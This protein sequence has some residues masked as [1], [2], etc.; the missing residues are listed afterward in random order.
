[1]LLLFSVLCSLATCVAPQAYA[2]FDDLGSSARPMGMGNAY[3]AIA[4]DVNAL[5]YN[6]AGLARLYA[7]E[8]TSSYTRYLIGL[9]DE[10]NLGGGY[11]A[12]ALPLGEMGGLGIGYTNFQLAGYY[13]EHVLTVGYGYQVMRELSVGLN[14]K[15][16]MS[17]IGQDAYTALD[18]LFAGGYSTTNF[19]VDLGAIYQIAP[20][21]RVALTIMNLNQP[22]MALAGEDRVPTIVKAGFA[23]RSYGLDVVSDVAYQTNTRDLDFYF[24]AEKWFAD[25]S[26]AMRAGL[27]FGSREDRDASVGASYRTDN[28]QMDY[29][30][31]YPL[32]GLTKTYGTHRMALS[33]RFGDVPKESE[34]DWGIVPMIPRAMYDEELEKVRAAAKATQVQVEALQEQLKK[35]ETEVRS[36]KSEVN[37]ANVEKLRTELNENSEKLASFMKM[38][39]DQQAK[40]NALEEAKKAKAAREAQAREEA[41]IVKEEVRSQKSEVSSQPTAYSPQPSVAGIPNT[42][43]AAE[44][45]T[46]RSVAKRFYGSE[47]KWVDIYRMNEDRIKQGIITPGQILIM[48]KGK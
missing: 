9:G 14:V 32:A 8:V 20:S 43:T 24:G 41:K 2:N 16:L 47:D 37:D 11:L 22:N 7:P 26:F 33:V 30:F 27:G 40:L 17:S 46:L 13:Q 25:R 23:Y 4:T 12:L 36:Q 1:M 15:G 38:Y 5:Y 31:L 45:D 3:I 18:P 44:G 35:Q 39:A 28:L 48:P 42:Y 19:S 34:S 29:A 10:S 21:Y 6:P